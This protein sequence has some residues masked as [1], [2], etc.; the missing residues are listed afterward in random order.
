M[1]RKEIFTKSLE[2]AFIS[3]VLYLVLNSAIDRKT[4][5]SLYERAGGR[6]ESRTRDA[7]GRERMN[8]CPNVR[9][10][11]VAHIQH[12]D[13]KRFNRLDNVRLYC[14]RC[15][16]F[17][18]LHR[19]RNNLSKGENDW[20]LYQLWHRMTLEERSGIPEPPIPKKNN[21]YRR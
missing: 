12:G 14:I 8:R 5:Q 16:Y 9:S 18:H 13:N 15:H 2:F 7:N 20:T 17:D 4:E 6:C 19:R 10:L 1:N 3:S 11:E 21:H